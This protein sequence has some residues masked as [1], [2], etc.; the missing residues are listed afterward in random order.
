ML[1]FLWSLFFFIVALGILVAVHE[2]GH[3]WVARRCGVK[4]ERF[5]IGFGKALWRTK[6]KYG[7]EFVVALI[8]LGGYVKMLDERVDHVRDE[9]LPHAFNRQSVYKR[10]AIIAAGPITNFLFAIVALTLMYM[11]GVQSVKPV[12]GQIKPDSLFSAVN[13]KTPSQIIAID[14]KPTRDWE[15][16]NLEMVSHIGQPSMQVTLQEVG[17]QAKVTKTIDI[18]DWQFDPQQQS[19]LDSLGVVPFRPELTTNIAWVAEDSAANRANILQ[20]DKII[21]LD[22]TPVDDWVQIVSY[23][24]ARPSQNVTIGVERQGSIQNIDVMLDSR[25]AE[26]GETQGYLGV[27]PKME[28]W[29]ESFR[30]NQQYDPLNAVWQGMIKT[31]RLIT[32]SVDMIG[33]LLTG[34]VSVK[35]LS[36]PIS[37]AQGAGASA[38]Y[39]LVYFLSFLALISVNLGIINLLPLP[40]LDGGHLLYY[41]IEMITGRPV[42]EKVQEIGFRIGGTLLFLLM[43]VAI[44]NDIARL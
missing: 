13:I 33:K 27:V 38:G 21:S 28:P 17:N 44:M 3:F 41:V 32:L 19:A 39:G 23:I 10:I 24:A 40:V 31:W 4:V 35:N 30:F 22:G 1:S 16:V 7:T 14:D 34:D 5:S 15:S 25:T 29:P 9:D 26:N 20:N 37:I 12:I 6:D 11:V 43:S 42:S 36:G 18:Q 2:W 8:P